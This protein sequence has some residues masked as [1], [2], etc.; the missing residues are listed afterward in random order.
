VLEVDGLLIMVDEDLLNEPAV[1]VEALSLLWDGLV[2]HPTSLLLPS[3]IFLYP[4]EAPCIPRKGFE[5]L[6]TR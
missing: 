4:D 1:V 6:F 5:Y 2:L 3:M